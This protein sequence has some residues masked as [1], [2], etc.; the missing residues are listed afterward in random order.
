MRILALCS[1]AAAAAAL[2]GA[3][4]ATATTPATVRIVV[5]PVTVAGYP[6]A[7][8]TVAQEPT[9]QVDC[10][11]PD[12]SPGAVNANILECSPSAEYAIACWKSAT[13]ARVLCLRN[14]RAH[15]LVKIPDTGRFA[16]VSAPRSTSPLSLVLSDGDTCSIR[17]GGAWG[18]L[19]LHPSWVGE[20]SCVHDGI[21]WG[22]PTAPHGGVI[23]TTSAWTVLTTPPSGI[24]PLITRHVSRAYFV[25]THA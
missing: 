10:S 4:A 8:Y 7:G 13:P 12:A 19:H 9:G 23:E 18:W 3:G 25:G 14:A 1:L 6:V 22:P 24:G 17:D 20:Y 21:V 16:R 15:T 11:Y 5:R 2:F